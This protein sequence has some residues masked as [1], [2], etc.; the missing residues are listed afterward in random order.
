M[1]DDRFADDRLLQSA[2]YEELEAFADGVEYDADDDGSVTDKEKEVINPKRLTDELWDQF[3]ATDSSAVQA[4]TA[5][6]TR[7]HDK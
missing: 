5:F 4:M 6:I 7:N 2:I 1:D 3:T